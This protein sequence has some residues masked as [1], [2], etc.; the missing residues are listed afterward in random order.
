MIFI[1]PP[2]A[3]VADGIGL[4]PAQGFGVEEAFWKRGWEG[5][6]SF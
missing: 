2:L 5:R 3:I 1:W 6:N 4:S